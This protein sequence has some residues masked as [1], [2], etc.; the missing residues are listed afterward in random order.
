MYGDD[1]NFTHKEILAMV[2]KELEVEELKAYRTNST[3]ISGILLA[4]EIVRKHMSI[5]YV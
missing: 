1:G 4:E 5:E 3:T 2:L